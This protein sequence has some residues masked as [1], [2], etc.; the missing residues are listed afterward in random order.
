MQVIPALDPSGRI[1]NLYLQFLQD[2][3]DQDFKGDLRQ[4]Y[5]TRLVTATD[6]SIYQVMPQA[7]V[8]PKDTEDLKLVLELS[9]EEQYQKISL[10]PRGGGTGTNGQSLSEGI[11]VD[12]SRHMNQILELNLDEAWVRIQPG[13][14]LDQLNDYLKPHGVFFAPNVSPS[15][16]ATL[17]GMINTDACGKGSRVY[18][19]TSNHILELNCVLSNGETLQSFPIKD[20]YLEE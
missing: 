10:T 17:G 18:G 4:D 9:A 11:I 8:F 3:E 7:V 16:R 14:V 12:C 13:V 1:D 15:S 6:N 2:L 20:E 19:R 5:G